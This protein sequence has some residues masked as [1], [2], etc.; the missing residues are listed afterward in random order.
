MDL[1]EISTKVNRLEKDIRELIAVLAGL[2][3]DIQMAVRG[4][5]RIKPGTGCKIYYDS[6]GLVMKSEDLEA[7]DIPMLP[8][9][10]IDGLLDRLQNKSSEPKENREEQKKI[11]AG[12]GIKINYDEYG[13]VTSSSKSLLPMDI[14]ELTMDKISGLEDVIKNIREELNGILNQRK[15]KYRVAPGTAVKVSYG[16]D[17]RIISG[18]ELTMDDIPRSLISKINLIESRI[19]ALASQEIVNTALNRLNKKLDAN[20]PI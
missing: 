19:P 4:K 16:E 8:I 10:K 3:I 5:E 17:G 9:E 1:N 11:K 6:N 20:I 2:R 12:S 14:P 15:E 7:S 18:S 13:R